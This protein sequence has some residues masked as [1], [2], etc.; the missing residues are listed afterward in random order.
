MLPVLL[1]MSLRVVRSTRPTVRSPYS[2]GSAPVNQRS[3]A[4]EIGIEDAAETGDAV[5]QKHAIDAELHIGM[6]V[7]HVKETARRGI[8]RHTRRLQ[9]HLLDR[10]VGA[11]RQRLDGVVADRVRRCADRGVEI[12]ARLIEAVALL[13]QDFG[14]RHRR[15]SCRRYCRRRG[16]PRDSAR[17]RSSG[18]AYVNLR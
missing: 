12:A 6:I 10:G 17:R 18:S 13:C 3:A 2:A 14:W 15:H 11:L 8:L 16:T 7:T 9:Q 1:K 5:R 4:D